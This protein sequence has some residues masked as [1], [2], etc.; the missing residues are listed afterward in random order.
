MLRSPVCA[1]VT[2]L[3]RVALRAHYDAFAALQAFV[4][5]SASL[6]S[7]QGMI[8]RHLDDRLARTRSAKARSASKSL[9][10]LRTHSRDN[11]TSLVGRDLAIHSHE[12]PVAFSISYTQVNAR[13]ELPVA[14]PMALQPSI[15]REAGFST[16][17]TRRLCRFTICR[18]TLKTRR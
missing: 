3:A 13:S 18:G 16:A 17:I 6:Y 1:C 11:G 7:S 2:W 10:Q 12:D 15:I 9:F 5:S 8:P 14:C 4:R